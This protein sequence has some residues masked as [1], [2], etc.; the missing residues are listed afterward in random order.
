MQGM[1]STLRREFFYVSDGK[2]MSINYDNALG[3]DIEYIYVNMYGVGGCSGSG[4]IDKNTKEVIGIF[5]GAAVSGDRAEMNY[6]IPVR[7]IWDL[8]DK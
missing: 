5:S 7:Y 6:L 4:V 3:N 1:K 2:I 8:L